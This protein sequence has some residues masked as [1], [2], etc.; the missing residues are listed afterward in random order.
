MALVDR[1]A[2][3]RVVGSNSNCLFRRE[4]NYRKLVIAFFF[5]NFKGF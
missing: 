5:F 3:L 4:E 2:A 1:A